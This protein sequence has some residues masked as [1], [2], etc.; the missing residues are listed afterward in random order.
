MSYKYNQKLPEEV[1]QSF[2]GRVWDNL[3]YFF[4]RSI[5][6]FIGHNWYLVD[7]IYG[8]E[9]NH[10]WNIKECSRCRKASLD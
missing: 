2:F 6:F 9:S 3:V 10:T 1:E 7:Y 4:E 8:V 5:C